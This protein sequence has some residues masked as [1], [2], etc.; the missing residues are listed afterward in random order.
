LCD[1]RWEPAQYLRYSDERARPFQDLVARVGAER[2][3]LVADLGCGPGTM[4]R[5]LVDRW[6]EAYVVGV[7][8][9][10]EMIAEAQRLQLP[11]RLEFTCADLRTWQA[12]QPVD[13]LLSNATLQ[14]VPDHIDLLPAL[15]EM[16]EYDGWLAFQVPGN[17]EEASHVILHELA[18]QPRWQARMTTSVQARA[19]VHEPAEYLER[20]AQVGLAVDAWETTYLHVLPG[21]DAVLEWMKGTGARPVL[22]A[23]SDPD[24]AEFLEE[25]G[26]VLRAAYPRQPFGTVMPFRRIFVVAHREA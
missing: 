19:A 17:F 4:T 8:S 16:L 1:V 6:P 22:D 25:Y 23:L 5:G 9:S 24:R 2:P 7:D 12:P 15:V 10:P 20:L 26:A 18:D 13:L 21:E 11:G 3:R 14:W